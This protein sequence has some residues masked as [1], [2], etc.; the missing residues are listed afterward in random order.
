[1]AAD[2]ELV[3]GPEGTDAGS[4]DKQDDTGKKDTPK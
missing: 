3:G 1:L 4:G 2:P